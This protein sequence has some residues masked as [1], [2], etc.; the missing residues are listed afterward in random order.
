MGTNQEREKVAAKSAES[1]ALPEA[2][3][4]PEATVSFR[5]PEETTAGCPEDSMSAAGN[6]DATS[7]QDEEMIG[8]IE[9][10]ARL[11]AQVRAHLGRLVRAS[12]SKLVE[13][14][15]PER[16]I[17]LLEQLERAETSN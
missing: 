4:A 17:D 16:F 8:A 6:D 11:D 14:P 9:H 1:S 13:E 15:V 5:Q 12:Y 7:G 10:S 2:A 3:A